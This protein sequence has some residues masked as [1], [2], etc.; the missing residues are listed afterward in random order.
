MKLIFI[1]SWDEVKSGVK[2]KTL[3]VWKIPINKGPGGLKK[4]EK[5][6]HFYASSH[7]NINLMKDYD[8]R[9]CDT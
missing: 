8:F 3:M 4:R 9:K 6:K 1:M 5:K 2:I 7:V